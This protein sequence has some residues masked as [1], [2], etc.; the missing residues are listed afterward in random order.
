M[1]LLPSLTLRYYM[2]ERK[3]YIPPST[4]MSYP[5]FMSDVYDTTAWQ[6]FMG[7]VCFLISRIGLQFCVDEIP[8]FDVGS[9]S[10]KP[11]EFIVLSLPPALR[12][13]S[14]YIL[15]FLLLP[16][17]LAK[18]ML[19]LYYDYTYVLYQYVSCKKNYDFLYQ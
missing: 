5:L 9:L 10:L 17:N 8:A 18:G 4:T 7:P 11:A 14:E 19:F 13:K 1:F 6:E 2:T 16:N 3:N 15:L 12:T